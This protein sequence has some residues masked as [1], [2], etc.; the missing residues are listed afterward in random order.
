MRRDA[1]LGEAADRSGRDPEPRFRRLGLGVF[2]C[3]WTLTPARWSARAT[4]E[5]TD[6]AA[7][8]DGSR[9]RLTPIHAGA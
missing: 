6:A 4:C 7:D 3:T 5:A 1:E 9:E 2:P 8:H